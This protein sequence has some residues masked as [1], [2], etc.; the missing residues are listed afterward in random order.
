MPSPEAMNLSEP[1]TQFA[2]KYENSK[3][4][5]PQVSPIIR[6]S[7]VA[8]SFNKRSRRDVNRANIDDLI[9]ASG[10]FNEIGY[11]VTPDSYQLVPRG[12]EAPVGRAETTVVNAGGLSPEEEA[13]AQVMQAI[14]LAHEYRVATVMTTTSSY[15]SDNR[16]TAGT[17]SKPATATPWS[18]HTSS[19]P[20]G[21]LKAAIRKLPSTGDE[22]ERV[23]WISDVVFDALVTHPQLLALKG[24][25]DG[26]VSE[27][28]LLKYIRGLDRV[29]VTDVRRDSANAGQSAVYARLWSETACGIV[30]V[31]KGAPTTQ[32]AVFA[33]TFQHTDGF[34]VRVEPDGRRGYGGSDI[35]IVEHYTQAAKV[36]QDDCGVIISSCL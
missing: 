19:D 28:E 6:V 21:D 5:A 14:M 31:P 30:S 27:E 3:M 24:T 4:I 23:L 34:R 7:A 15:A 26:V 20:V 11:T 9:G 18:N 2:T 1:L 32:S 17:Q 10:R 13:V 25:T 12:L 8:G 36:V 16:H 22:F 35:H 33:P 29:V